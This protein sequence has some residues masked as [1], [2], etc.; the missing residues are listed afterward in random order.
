MQKYLPRKAELAWQVSRYLWRPPWNF[1]IVFSI[2]LFTIILSQ[3]WCQI[4]VRF[5]CV[6]PGTKN[7]QCEVISIFIHSFEQVNES[8]WYHYNV[9]ISEQF[10]VYKSCQGQIYL[11]KTADKK[12]LL[13]FLASFHCV[14]GEY[15]T[16]REDSFSSFLENS[17]CHCEIWFLTCDVMTIMSYQNL[18]SKIVIKMWP[19]YRIVASSNVRY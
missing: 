5:F 14:C 3:K 12:A 7:L 13:P 6:L 2:P 11:A 15:H 19:D 1:K 17:C 10:V 16:M 18:D 9:Q 8:Y 4:S